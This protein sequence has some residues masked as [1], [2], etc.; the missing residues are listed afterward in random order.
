[1]DSYKEYLKSELDA[2]SESLGA[3]YRVD[4][5]LMQEVA[6]YVEAGQGKLLR[7]AIVCLVARAFGYSGRE[8]LHAR[9]GAAVELFHTATLLHDDVIDNAALRRRRPTVNAKWGNDVAILFADYLYATCFDH[10]LAALSPEIVRVLTKTTQ[11]MTEG[12]MYQIEKRG[13][14][15]SVADYFSIIRAKTAHLFSASAGFGA[16]IAGQRGEVLE[17]MFEFG[18]NFGMAFQITDD[19]LDYEAQGDSWGKRVG[20]DLKEGKQTLPLL[21]ALQQASDADRAAL[22]E[23]LNN[24]RDFDAVHAY[25]KQYN[26][27]DYSLEKAGDF[28]KAAMDVLESLEENEAIAHLKRITDS[29]L[30]RQA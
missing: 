22:V 20:A 21:H 30:V 28:T 11:K 3:A 4:G 16:M 7:P 8:N 25:V 15:L 2:L 24:G 23:I 17:Q 19:A 10:A 27:I 5:E 14:W 9:L 13:D 26:G 29:V 6:S 18:M 12:E 1:M